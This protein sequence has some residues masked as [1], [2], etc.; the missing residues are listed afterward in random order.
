[1]VPFRVNLFLWLLLFVSCH[2]RAT[3]LVSSPQITQNIKEQK[4]VLEKIHKDKFRWMILQQYDSLATIMHKDMVYIHSNGW[5]ENK[6]EMMFNM[7]SGKLKY[8]KIVIDETNIRLDGNTGI[9]TGKGVFNV[10][11]EGKPL[12]I[13]LYYTEVYVYKNN[14][15]LFL[16][17]HACKI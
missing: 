16:S 3:H 10:S 8:D 11:L 17:R 7:Q 13:K 1:M 14:R 12:E 6:D 5:T 15:Y 2:H 9:V 4:A